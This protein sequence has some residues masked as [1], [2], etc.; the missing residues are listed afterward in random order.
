MRVSYVDEHFKG[1]RAHEFEV[2]KAWLA[3]AGKPVPS[4][5][6]GHLRMIASW[7]TSLRYETRR[8][9]AKDAAAFLTA[10]LKIIDWGKENIS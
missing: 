5:V 7:D 1:A 4:S 2:L 9:P 6:A 8:V 10:V 3:K